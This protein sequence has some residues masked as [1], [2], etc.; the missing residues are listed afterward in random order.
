MTATMIKTLLAVTFIQILLHGISV[1]GEPA[2][3]AEIPMSYIYRYSVTL[4]KVS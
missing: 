4:G 2:K 3:R 1:T